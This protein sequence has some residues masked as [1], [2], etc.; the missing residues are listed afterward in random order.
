MWIVAKVKAKEL[1]NFKKNLTQGS[2]SEIKFYCPKI[3]YYKNFKNKMKKYE[4]HLLENYIFCFHDKFKKS[5][6]LNELKFTK[7]LDYFLSGNKENQEEIKNFVEHC[8]SCENKDGY[9]SSEFFKN[10]ITNKAKFISGPF[11]SMMFEVLDRRKNKLKI[12]VGNIVTTIS[13]KTNYLY[14]PI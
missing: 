9:L 12:L 6:F 10:I 3:E 14:R 5:I 4:K 7:G 2:N 13:D 8:I 1:E 11:T